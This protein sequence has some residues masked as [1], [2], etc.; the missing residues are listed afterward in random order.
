M[1]ID[2]KEKWTNLKEIKKSLLT[3]KAIILMIWLSILP[4]GLAIMWK[5]IIKMWRKKSKK[6]HQT[7]LTDWVE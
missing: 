4:V 6:E 5:E 7:S 2:L 3:P 1:F